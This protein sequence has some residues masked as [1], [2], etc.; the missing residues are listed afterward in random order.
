MSSNPRRSTTAR[1]SGVTAGKP[2]ATA[3]RKEPPTKKQE[4]AAAKAAKRLLPPPRTYVAIAMKAANVTDA[5]SSSTRPPKRAAAAN[6][7]Y[8]NGNQ[9]RDDEITGDANGDNRQE[10]HRSRNDDESENGSQGGGDNAEYQQEDEEEEEVFDDDDEGARRKRRPSAKQQQLN[11]ERLA[12]QY[13]QNREAARRAGFA[14]PEPEFEPREYT[15][16]PTRDVDTR[17]DTIKT[18]AHRRMYHGARHGSQPDADDLAPLGK[19]VFS[20]PPRK[21]PQEE[22]PVIY[23]SNGERALLPV[24]L[25]LHMPE[26]WETVPDHILNPTNASSS[27]S[28]RA[29]DSTPDDDMSRPA[30]PEVGDK[31]SVSPSIGDDDAR[32]AATAAT[33]RGRPTAGA[34][35]EDVKEVTNEAI[36]YLRC[37]VLVNE[38]FPDHTEERKMVKDAFGAAKE[39][40]A[41]EVS[42]TTPVYKVMAYRF[43][44]TRGELKSK[45]RPIVESVYG[46][47]HGSS[48]KT[49]KYN[50]K[51][52]EDL[53][54]D[55][56]FVYR[57][58][59][60]KSGI[61]QNSAIQKIENCIDEWASGSRTDINFTANE[62]RPVYEAH[63][64]ALEAFK[65]AGSKTQILEKILTRIHAV[66]RFNSGAEPLTD[67]KPKPL[68][69]AQ[70]M[71]AAVADFEDKG[72]LSDDGS[73][74]ELQTPTEAANIFLMF[75][76]HFKHLDTLHID[77]DDNPGWE[78]R[79]FLRVFAPFV[80][81]HG[82]TLKTLHIDGAWTRKSA[83][84]SNVNAKRP[85][86]IL[87]PP[88][89]QSPDI[90]LPNLLYFCVPYE[91]LAVAHC[92][93]PRLREISIDWTKLKRFLGTAEAPMIAHAI[94]ACKPLRQIFDTVSA[95]PSRP[96]IC[97]NKISEDGGAREKAALIAVATAL[98]DIRVVSMTFSVNRES[99]VEVCLI[100]LFFLSASVPDAVPQL[101]SE[102][103][104]EGLRPFKKL[105]ILLLEASYD[106]WHSDHEQYLGMWTRACPTL[107]AVMFSTTDGWIKGNLDVWVNVD[108]EEFASR[109]GMES[110][111]KDIHFGDWNPPPITGIRYRDSD[112][113]DDDFEEKDYS[114]L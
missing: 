41:V 5:A 67:D 95:S 99:F 25:N 50:R 94:A 56:S 42:L 19:V 81:R 44:H 84:P 37:D 32:Y 1:T 48:K 105:E 72:G 65:V 43:S 45:A 9:H 21:V 49:I 110:W 12:M 73:D 46:F 7:A 23:N 109:A 31:R 11:E 88:P 3:P 29:R 107:R 26:R 8:V 96:F 59:Q 54:E 114:W 13:K 79:K 91:F 112:D 58:P 22:R 62:Y 89:R 57:F 77:I 108:L 38:G 36:K 71:A 14:T 40:L 2:A 17:L 76:A 104:E 28:R 51:L 75:N 74:V 69:S 87:L 60:D 85:S 83:P 4:A 33:G 24:K 61:Y 34:L 101:V 70:M 15:E 102:S 27:R 86:F 30:S 47:Q 52:A 39:D 82:E 100:F 20:A 80:E 78:S 97:H 68:M 111:F 10:Y 6:N 16:Y 106:F 18:A 63:I 98:P 93:F 53:K 90:S 64:E 55:I 103:I 92:A 66:G 35:P 113:E